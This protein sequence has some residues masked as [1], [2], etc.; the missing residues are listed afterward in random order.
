MRILFATDGSPEALRA[1]ELLGTLA[2]NS[3]TEI[4]IASVVPRMGL[5]EY[6]DPEE[7]DGQPW[8]SSA[9]LRAAQAVAD[10]AAYRLAKAGVAT[11][12]LVTGGHP[13]EEICR[14]AEEKQA[15]FIVMGSH[16]R[17]GLA[18]FFLGSVSQRVVK[19][20]PCPVLAVKSATV[21]IERVLIGVDGSDC[22]RRALAFVRW[23]PFPS[24]VSLTV[25]HVVHV[26]MP[27]RGG[28]GGHYES[29]ELALAVEKVRLAA[30]AEGKRILE[31]A[32]ECLR[33]AHRVETRMAT[34]PPA[35]SLVD[36]AAST[37]A[38]LVVVGSRGLTGVKRFLLGS[39]S[40]QVCEHAPG[41]VLVVR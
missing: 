19:H 28:T 20:A 27:F 40:L 30:E 15:A 11:E 4:L 33:N 5:L 7:R 34:G 13:A 25:A 1:Q 2:L 41:S 38:D 24:N 21:S 3:G 9:E 8:L 17:S 18:R 16:G 14:M 6:R 36:L 31:E 10:E 35:R 32:S 37:N 39:V 26:P 29:E 23:F 22:S 12:S